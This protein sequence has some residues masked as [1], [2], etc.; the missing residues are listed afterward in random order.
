MISGVLN[1]NYH[2]QAPENSDAAR[3][4]SLNLAIQSEMSNY[5]MVNSK[6][7][8]GIRIRKKVKFYVV[9]NTYCVFNLE[10]E[11][12]LQSIIKIFSPAQ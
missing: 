12:F 4:T 8:F 5:L 1:N 3:L 9:R 10:V 7:L 6:L 2:I 11:R